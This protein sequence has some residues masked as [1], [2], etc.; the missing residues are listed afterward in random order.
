MYG[1]L[2][3]A[4]LNHIRFTFTFDDFVKHPFNF[5]QRAMSSIMGRRHGITGWTGQITAV[6]H[7]DDRKATVLFMIDA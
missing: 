2:S 6:G 3:T 1:W 7:L 4:D 5:F